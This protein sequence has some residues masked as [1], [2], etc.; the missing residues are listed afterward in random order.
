MA[1]PSAPGGR[2]LFYLFNTQADKLR[3]VIDIDFRSGV[4]YL[5][6]AV[7]LADRDGDPP[8]SARTRV[9]FAIRTEQRRGL[10]F[11]QGR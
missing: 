7:R 10:L 1:D 9:L 11:S 8:L 3:F 2:D 5:H 4:D 6:L